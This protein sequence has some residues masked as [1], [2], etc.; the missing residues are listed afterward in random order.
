MTNQRTK[1]MYEYNAKVISVYDAD[2]ITVDIDLGF[3]TWL[4]NQKVRLYGINA[5]EV[6]RNKAKKIGDEHVAKGKAG[7]DAVR[8]IMADCDN[9]IIIK[10]VA[11]AKGK[12]G[13]WLAIVYVDTELKN[14][15]LATVNYRTMAELN[16]WLVTADHAWVA[17]Y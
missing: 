1:T 8:Q 9:Q 12:Y 5:Y 6:R 13:R 2:T 16:D 15:A 17:V 4:H 7:R 11:K 3:G 10:T 14:A